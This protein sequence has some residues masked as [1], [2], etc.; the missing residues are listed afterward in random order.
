MQFR[1]ME[2]SMSQVISTNKVKPG[3]EAILPGTVTTTQSHASTAYLAVLSSALLAACSS[4]DD[5]M[6]TQ[7]MTAVGADTASQSRGAK[8]IQQADAIN[9]DNLS[10]TGGFNNFPQAKTTKDAARFLLQSQLNASDSEI[11][12]VMGGTFA[13]YLQKQFLKPI[14][15]T[16]WDWLEAR[17]YGE[18]NI[19]N[20]LFYAYPADCMIWNQLFTAQD[21]MR[22]RMALALSEFFVASLQTAEFNWRSHAYAQ[23]WDTLV[24]HAFGNFRQLLEAITLNPA[25]GY[26]L[27]AKGSLKENAET[28]RQPDEN[29]AR[30]V[31]QLFTIGLYQLNLDGTEKVDANNNKIETY[32]Q[33]DVSH[34]ARVFTG[35]DLDNAQGKASVDIYNSDGS[36]AAF[37]ADSRDSVRRPMVLNASNHSNLEASFLGTTIPAGTVGGLALQTAFNT[38][39]NH[40][41]VGPFFGRQMIQRLV[42]SNPSPAYVAR[43]AAA[44]NN[45][46]AGVRGDLKAVWVAI[47]LDDEAREKKAPSDKIFGKLR[48]PMLRFIQWGRSFGLASDYPSWKIPDTSSSAER[49]GQSPLRAPSVFNYFRPGFAPPSKALARVKKLAPEFQLVNETTVAGYLNFMQYVIRSGI[50]SNDPEVP[51]QSYNTFKVNLKAAYTKEMALVADPSALMNHLNLILCAGQLSL[52]NQTLMVDALTSMPVNSA[53]PTTLQAQK[54]DRIGAAVLMVMASSEYLIQK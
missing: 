9:F 34:L 26:F 10:S 48:E 46:G 45:N 53:D 21:S 15:Q 43:V 14:G 36:L 3:T 8:T 5:G 17:G 23:Y 35:Y 29:Y 49:L 47:F 32:V 24:S 13:G 52:A 38:L 51:Q 4:S 7:N 30:E 18:S 33:R 54:L 12:V 6:E 37:K 31:M 27:N 16:G 42:T 39:F 40:P 19:H 2:R 25:M 22:K 1:E 44:F 11:A 20:Y 50:Y 28:G 41:N